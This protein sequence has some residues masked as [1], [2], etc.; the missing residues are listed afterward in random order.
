MIR[1]IVGHKGSGKTK[2]MIDMINNSVKDTRGN[3][4][5]IEKQMKLTY[6]IDHSVRLIDVDEYGIEGGDMFYGFVSGIL[7]SNYDISDVYIDGI[8]RILNRDTELLGDMLDK[9]NKLSG[10]GIKFTVTVSADT[11]DLPD[12]V[13]KYL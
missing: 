1:L 13:K 7:A 11:D 8:L 3:I 4:I 5:C 10:D 9:F 6:D 12:S 2:T